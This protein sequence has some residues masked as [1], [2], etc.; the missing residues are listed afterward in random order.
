[1]QRTTRYLKIEEVAE[2]LVLSRA[3]IY[4]LVRLGL[5]PGPTK[6]TKRSSRW[7]DYRV[8]DWAKAREQS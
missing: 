2:I 5:F 7:P 8:F 6:I 3:G 1:M 4:K